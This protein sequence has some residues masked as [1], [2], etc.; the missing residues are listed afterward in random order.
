MKNIFRNTTICRFCWENIESD[1]VID[2][3]HLTVFYRGPTHNTYNIIVIQKRSKFIPLVFHNFSKY[4]CR[5]FFKKIVGRKNE[6]VMFDILP[7]TIEEDNSVTNGCIRFVDSCRF[8]S[9]SLDEVVENLD[10]DDLNNLKL[11]ILNKWQYLNEKSAY[12]FE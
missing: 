5:V 2:H 10:K 4:D 1:K 3:C 12:P 6:R 7:K 9:Y 11:K 8:L